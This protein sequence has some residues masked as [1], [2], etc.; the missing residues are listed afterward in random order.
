MAE[1][2]TPEEAVA[3][4]AAFLGGFRTLMLATCGEG[5]MPDASYAPFV[6]GR[7]NVFYV[8]VSQLARHTANLSASRQASV[9]V[10]EN[11]D[12][13]REVFA[14]RRLTFRCTAEPIERHSSHWD[15][16]MDRFGVQFGEVIEFIRPLE[17]FVLFAL[18][19]ESAVFV[20]GFAQAHRFEGELLGR[21]ASINDGGF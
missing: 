14:R 12:T 17:D 20:E 6:R 11:E 19:A 13:A 7:H 3:K 15:R 4:A 16:V 8:Y 18:R 9:L 1:R 2:A 10:I 5:G 21:L